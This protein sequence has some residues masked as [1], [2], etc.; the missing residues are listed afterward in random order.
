MAAEEGAGEEPK[1]KGLFCQSPG[2]SAKR[3][4][5]S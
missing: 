4:M 1:W 5:M 2:W 3:M